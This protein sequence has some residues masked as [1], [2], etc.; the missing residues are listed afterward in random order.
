MENVTKQNYENVLKK[1][2]AERD[3]L[4]TEKRKLIQDTLNLKAEHF[5]LSGV[6]VMKD[7]QLKLTAIENQISQNN[8]NIAFLRENISMVESVIIS[9]KQCVV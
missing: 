2:E 6:S 9:A 7:R 8:E 5:V 3:R 4:E 1:Y